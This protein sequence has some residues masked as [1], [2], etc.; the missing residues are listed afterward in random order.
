MTKKITIEYWAKGGWGENRVKYMFDITV[1]QDMWDSLSDAG[2]VGFLQQQIWE[3]MQ[4]GYREVES[5]V[6]RNHE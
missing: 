4:C 2:R 6:P 1:R 5:S 3:D